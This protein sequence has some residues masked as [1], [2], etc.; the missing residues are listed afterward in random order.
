MLDEVKLKAIELIAKGL[1]KSDIAKEL[2]IGRTTLYY[3]EQLPEFKEALNVLEQ[4]F[5]DQVRRKLNYGAISA[6]DT[7]IDLVTKANSERVKREAASD[8]LDRTHGKAADKIE[9]TQKEEDKNRISVDMLK[10]EFEE[11]ENGK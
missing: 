1:K 6:A 5:K 11:F 8:I 7:L 9:L 3:W 4:E 2:K 10:Q